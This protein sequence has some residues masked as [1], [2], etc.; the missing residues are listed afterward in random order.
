MAKWYYE[1]GRQQYGPVAEKRLRGL[2]AQGAVGPGS[3]VWTEG[4][5]EWQRAF[6]IEALFPARNRLPRNRLP[7]PRQAPAPRNSPLMEG[8]DD[9]TIGQV[10]RDALTALKTRFSTYLGISLV[11]YLVAAVLGGLLGLAAYTTTHEPW[12]TTPALVLYFLVG[13]L[14]SSFAFMF[15]QGVVTYAAFLHLCGRRIRFSKAMRQGLRQGLPLLGM[16]GLLGVLGTA[17]LYGAFMIIVTIL[18]AG[19]LNFSELSALILFVLG[20]ILVVILF[21]TLPVCLVEKRGLVASMVRSASLTKGCRWKIS[22]IYLSTVLAIIVSLAGIYAL[23]KGLQLEEK[24]LELILSLSRHFADIGP[25][26]MA[27]VFILVAFFGLA[28]NFLI[29][30]VATAL[31]GAVLAATY[32]NLRRAKERIAVDHPTRV[33][34]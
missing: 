4:M 20:N 26:L 24:W 28:L 34:Y 27:L 10:F 29:G 2:L 12:G 33:F 7:R 3:P 21:V 25:G 18:A 5:A 30:A 6:E 17:A 22:V 9:F 23:S 1:V 13:P 32:A 19:R 8:T 16:G 11:P 15:A 31:V 14:V